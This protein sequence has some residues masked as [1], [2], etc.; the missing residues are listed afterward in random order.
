MDLFQMDAPWEE[1]ARR[2]QVFKLYGEW[3]AYHATDAELRTAVA[4]IRRRGLAL[5]VEA[6]PL[7]PTSDCGQGVEGFAGTAE[8]RLIARRIRDAGGTIDLVALDEPFFF[9]HLYDGPNACHWPADR[10]AEGVTAFIRT[11]RSF[12]PEVIV[13]DT[14]PLAGAAGPADYTSW[15]ETFRSVAGNDLAFLHMD[16]DWGRPAWPEQVLEIER[17]GRNFGV[18]VGIIYNGN[19]QDPSDEDWLS[20]AGERVI[21]Y[22]LEAGGRPE[23]VLFQSW[24][25]HPDRALPE[26]EPY[27][28]TG[29]IVRYFADRTSL[30]FRTEGRGAN[31]AL[32][33]STRVSRRF[34]DYGGEFAADGDSNTSW[35]SG[36]FAPQWIEIDLGSPHDIQGLQLIIAQSP[37][38]ETEHRVLGRGPAATDAFVLLHT[39]AGPT[40]DSQTLSFAPDVPWSEVQFIRVQTVRSPS[41][42]G[43]REVRILDAGED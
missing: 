16:I 14:E 33:K 28:F 4:D 34:E 24:Q 1:S 38:G 35:N 10:I 11:M 23:H 32:G 30:G 43:W 40:A 36:D 39:F 25:D 41:W 2:I 7:D 18:P 12:F 29:F 20:I 13:G 15:L 8:A 22:E 17:F 37:A 3:V 21:D 5:A 6:G 31:L 9:A 19:Y 26:T 27:T 42:V